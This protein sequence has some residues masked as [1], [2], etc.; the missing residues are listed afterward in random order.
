M[1]DP[2]F[3]P[4]VMDVDVEKAVRATLE[5]WMP[6]YLREIERRRG[7]AEFDF[8]DIAA[9][10]AMDIQEER[11]PEEQIPA[12]Q[13]MLTT[14]TEIFTRA[15]SASA[16]WKGPIDVLVSTTE[17]ETAREMASYY[18]F[19]MGLVLVQH[20]TLDG[21]ITVA[22]LGWEKMGIPAVGKPDERWLALGSIDISIEVDGVFNP[23]LGPLVPQ[24][25][26]G[27]G[28]PPPYGVVET[29]HLDL[30]PA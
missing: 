5:R 11:F 1:S 14:E 19:C 13:I 16:I 4:M 17:P 2:V 3:G 21:S 8:P 22:G 25:D 12:V 26:D 30:E 23:A 9:Y 24:P 6:T 7:F 15:E 28:E 20:F 29:H 27:E 18:Q 10:R